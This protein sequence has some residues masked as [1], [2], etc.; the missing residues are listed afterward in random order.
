MNK[1]STEK[2]SSNISVDEVLKEK[3][4]V[5]SHCVN[6][7]CKKQQLLMLIE[8][9]YKISGE[10]IS[11]LPEEQGQNII[12]KYLN[13]AVSYLSSIGKQLMQ[14]QKSRKEIDKEISDAKKRIELLDN[15]LKNKEQG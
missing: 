11:I 5:V 6:L 2:N 13:S 3:K 15:I 7:E 14:A 8:K 10:R 4:K 1:H 12:S 9:L